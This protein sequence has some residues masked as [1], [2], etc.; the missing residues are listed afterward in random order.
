MVVAALAS[1][2]GQ[3]WKGDRQREKRW[4]MVEV[5]SRWVNALNVPMSTTSPML[6]SHWT[7]R[8]IR[9]GVVMAL[10]LVELLAV[11]GLERNSFCEWG[12]V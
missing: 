8:L 1:V 5:A 3:A 4:Y 12:K 7:A 10:T 6:G 9:L 11:S 2:E